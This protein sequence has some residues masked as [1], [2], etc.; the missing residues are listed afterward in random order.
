[1]MSAVVG[2]AVTSVLASLSALPAL[3]LILSLLILMDDLHLEAAD[4]ERYRAKP[5]EGD[6]AHHCA[7][8]QQSRHRQ[9]HHPPQG[10]E[11]ADVGGT[12]KRHTHA[13]QDEKGLGE[14]NDTVL[15]L[16]SSLCSHSS[17][18]F[19]QGWRQVESTCSLN[20]LSQSKR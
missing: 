2:A 6:T 15:L 20:C 7:L 1:M 11:A 4:V 3:L 19:N 18:Q 16:M 17:L 10:E 8:E 13:S 5:E 14:Q 12:A 9:Q